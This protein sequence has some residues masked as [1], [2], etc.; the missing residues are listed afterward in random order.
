M[1]LDSL[2]IRWEYEAEGLLV[3]PRLDLDRPPIQ[4]LPDF[5]LPDLGAYAE[6]KGQW[7]SLAEAETWLECAASLTC[8][9]NTG[10]P[11]GMYLLGHLIPG[12]SP[13]FF[14]MWKGDLSVN[15][16]GFDD[17][18]GYTFGYFISNDGGGGFAHPGVPDLLLEG[19]PI[20]APR[21]A[22]AVARARSYRFENGR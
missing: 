16:A 17:T 22:D 10:K 9:R 14:R 8:D 7:P 12:R 4:Y 13:L 3:Q 2:H 1:V 6:V 11:G 5:W 18:D 21:L 15:P 20:R 19:L